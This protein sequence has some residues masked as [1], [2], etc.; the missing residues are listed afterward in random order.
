MSFHE[1]LPAI[2]DIDLVL[3]WCP[4]GLDTGQCVVTRL[5]GTVMALCRYFFNIRSPSFE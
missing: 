3:G 1:D 5:V 4:S 2:A